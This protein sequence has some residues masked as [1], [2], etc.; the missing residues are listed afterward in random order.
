MRMTTEKEDEKKK[1][2]KE[3]KRL[4][5]VCKM[6]QRYINFLFIMPR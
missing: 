5:L 6:E 3:G 4:R 1:T 2:L